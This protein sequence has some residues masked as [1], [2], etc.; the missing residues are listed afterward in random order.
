[1]SE[2]PK[3]KPSIPLN[4]HIYRDVKLENI[5]IDEEG[6]ARLCDFGMSKRCLHVGDGRTQSIAGTLQYVAPEVSKDDLTFLYT[7][8]Y[9]YGLI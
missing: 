9:T 4:T 6:H 7:Y 3:A 5:L 8:T 1:M 2:I